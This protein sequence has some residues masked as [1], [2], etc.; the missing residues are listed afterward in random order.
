[1]YFSS[2]SSFSHMHSITVPQVCR[3]GDLNIFC[4]R[5]PV[6]VWLPVGVY[7]WQRAALSST[8]ARCNTLE[9]DDGEQEGGVCLCVMC[10]SPSSPAISLS[11][12]VRVLVCMCVRTCVFLPAVTDAIVPRH[13]ALAL[14]PQ[15]RPLWIR[16]T[17]AVLCVY[18]C[19]GERACICVDVHSLAACAFV[20][21]RDVAEG[22][23][24]DCMSA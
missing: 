21:W 16:N 20:Y 1:M 14:F 19:V 10:I 15:L 4:P 9:A 7:L 13:W 3:E 22:V 23:N 8:G 17:T 11:V 18:V 6:S 5:Q 24:R 2:L 12:C